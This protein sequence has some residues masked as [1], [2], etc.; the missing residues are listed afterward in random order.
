MML[1]LLILAGLA[2]WLAFAIRACAHR[3]GG[4]GGNCAS[5]GGCQGCKK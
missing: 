5:C 4:C 2:T 1:E 3:K